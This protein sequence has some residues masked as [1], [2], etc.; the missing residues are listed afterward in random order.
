MILTRNSN[1]PNNE[2]VFLRI[3]LKWKKLYMN[4]LKQI[5]IG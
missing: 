3:V 1:I 4:L 2:F 5:E